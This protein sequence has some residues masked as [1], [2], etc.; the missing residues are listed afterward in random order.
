MKDENGLEKYINGD[1]LYTQ[2]MNILMNDR[3]RNWYEDLGKYIY[4]KFDGN[5]PGVLSFCSNE[6]K[7]GILNREKNA[8]RYRMISIFFLTSFVNFDFM[9]KNFGKG[10]LHNEFGEG[11]DE[12][13]NI[14]FEYISYFIE[15]DNVKLHIGFDHRG[16]SIEVEEGTEPKKLFETLKKLVDKI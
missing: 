12:E 6:I 15:I 10:I 16:T 7:K 4:D 3:T 13:D 14:P 11:F 8:D 2:N 1:V 9:L 5:L